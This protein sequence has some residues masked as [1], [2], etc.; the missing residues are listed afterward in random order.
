VNWTTRNVKHLLELSSLFVIGGF[1]TF[2]LMIVS[3]LY[4]FWW[5]A[6]AQFGVGIAIAALVK[7]H[8]PPPD[9]DGSW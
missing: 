6:L 8:G 4:H 1:L 9:W 2:V 7:R 3:S 5:L